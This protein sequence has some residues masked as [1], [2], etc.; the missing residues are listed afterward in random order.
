[1]TKK[2]K[3]TIS[4]VGALLFVAIILTGSLVWY[5]LE[6]NGDFYSSV[7]IKYDD[8]PNVMQDNYAYISDKFFEENDLEFVIERSDNYYEESWDEVEIR[9]RFQSTRLHFLDFT[10]RNESLDYYNIVLRRKDGS[11]LP[12]IKLDI[13]CE[14]KNLTVLFHAKK[15][16]GCSYEKY[17]ATG[18]Y[19]VNTDKASK[20]CQFSVR[21][22]VDSSNIYSAEENQKTEIDL[23]YS[24]IDN[25]LSYDEIIA[26]REV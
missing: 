22:S 1:M 20:K 19:C 9:G 13:L 17:D 7:F 26:R 18:W 11:D 6:N 12:P 10:R 23:V 3:I 16:G 25:I 4:I 24:L 5:N 15:Y 21:I 2:S 8:L 14:N